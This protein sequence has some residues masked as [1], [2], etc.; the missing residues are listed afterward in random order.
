MN[1]YGIIIIFFALSLNSFSVAVMSSTY[2]CQK[3]NELLKT[4]LSLGL[5]QG[6]MYAFGW[7][8]ALAFKNLLD[9]IARPFVIM[10]LI[11]IGVKIVFI[12]FRAK[13]ADRAF[14]VSKIKVLIGVSI[15]S[16][17]NT[18]LIGI[19]FCLTR[20]SLMP[21]LAIVAIFSF[22][23]AVVGIIVGKYG[24][25]LKYSLYSEFAGGALIFII[26]I[27]LLLQYLQ[28]M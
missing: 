8:L 16:S 7:V 24:G 14:D 13:P 17:I 3:L 22:I 27:V 25:K 10:V 28:L 2:R 5:F 4:S 26:G 1:I 15:A 12:S 9:P 21:G 19:C 18:F 20:I 6:G 11:L 23:L